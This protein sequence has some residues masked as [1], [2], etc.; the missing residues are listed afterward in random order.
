MSDNKI[1][2]EKDGQN[3]GNNPDHSESE[4][5]KEN[6][7]HDN[8][9][10]LPENI[11]NDNENNVES[12]DINNID[13]SIESNN[14]DGFKKSEITN[15]NQASLPENIMNDN[16]KNVESDDINNI[17]TLI[18]SNN[19]D[20][21]KKNQSEITNENHDNQASLSENNMDDDDEIIDLE[22]PIKDPILN[23]KKSNK[24]SINTQDTSTNEYSKQVTSNNHD[25]NGNQPSIKQSNSSTIS[26]KGGRP[27][28]SKKD[29][30][31]YPEDPSHKM[32]LKLLHE[33][34]INFEDPFYTEFQFSD[35]NQ[36][37]LREWEKRKFIPTVDEYFKKFKNVKIEP[38]EA[39]KD[40]KKLKE[41]KM[42]NTLKYQVRKIKEL[43]EENKKLK[44]SKLEEKKP[45]KE[46]N[47][48]YTEAYD[49]FNNQK[50]KQ[51][52]EVVEI[53]RTEFEE[54]EKLFLTFM[55][56]YDDFHFD[57]MEVIE[58]EVDKIIKEKKVMIFPVSLNDHKS[59]ID[60]LE[61]LIKELD[62]LIKNDR[63]DDNLQDTFL[64]LPGINFRTSLELDYFFDDTDLSEKEPRIFFKQTLNTLLLI[65]KNISKKKKDINKLLA[66]FLEKRQKLFKE[67]K[68]FDPIDLIAVLSGDKQKIPE[69]TIIKQIKALLED[70]YKAA[71]D[72]EDV[73]HKI[74]KEYCSIIEGS[75]VKAY[76]EIKN[77]K[78]S[79]NK[80]I[81]DFE[82]ENDK[83]SFI[84]V[85]KSMYEKMQNMILEHL[86]KLDI[87]KIEC[88]TGDKYNDYFH[89]PFDK[90]EKDDEL[91]NDTIK[92]IINEGFM[93]K[94]EDNEYIIKAV[95]VIVVK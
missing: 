75:W 49:L 56:S 81:E 64:G 21:F 3:M 26:D 23:K 34:K 16:E 92:K 42:L 82:I 35:K 48:I 58:E 50:G 7:N 76:N 71:R 15:D 62:I 59:N 93:I 77:A 87:I 14:P 68:I 61:K 51:D 13:T 70:S 18:E 91:P 85:W 67:I 80:N 6:E 84:E 43:E 5:A 86:K 54:W 12:D 57:L 44:E 65:L 95:D 1:N 33:K 19:P 47:K 90:S 2:S 78:E 52:I 8:Q 72:A 45:Q 69:D 24:N 32:L 10:S 38:N 83:K 36:K 9:A 22:D 31:I 73:L 94:N 79:F 53:I 27:V 20:G 11:M 39:I 88:E 17:D 4:T 41:Q 46:F 29:L 28:P 37:I 55:N 40:K 25:I 30:I 60:R 74:I 89:K 63:F 66:V